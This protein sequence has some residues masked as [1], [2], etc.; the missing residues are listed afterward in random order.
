[1]A[2]G[3]VLVGRDDELAAL[4]A[5]S[6]AAANPTVVLLIGEAGIGIPGSAMR[7]RCRAGGRDASAA[8]RRGRRD[9]PAG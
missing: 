8:R 2:G 4:R 3:D 7:P 9:P 6:A 5:A 1:M